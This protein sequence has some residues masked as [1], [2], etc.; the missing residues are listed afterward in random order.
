MA[1]SWNSY[2]ILGNVIAN[3]TVFG[4][5]YLSTSWSWRVPYLMQV[6][7]ALYVSFRDPPEKDHHG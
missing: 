6:P 2:Y 3:F 4:T 7:M 5:S 1:H